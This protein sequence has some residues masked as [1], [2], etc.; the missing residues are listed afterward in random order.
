MIAS[1]VYARVFLVPGREL[2]VNVRLD[3]PQVASHKV[4]YARNSEFAVCWRLAPVFGVPGQMVGLTPVDQKHLDPKIC[5]SHTQQENLV[6]VVQLQEVVPNIADE[7][8]Y[9]LLKLSLPESRYVG[10]GILVMSEHVD[11]RCQLARCQLPLRE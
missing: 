6:R 4:Y 9:L 11:F 5:V 1:D 3:R 8:L 2:I 7:L 10:V